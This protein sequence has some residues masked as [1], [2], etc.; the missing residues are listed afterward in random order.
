MGYIKSNG[1]K[2]MEH[3]KKND[4]ST[5]LFCPSTSGNMKINLAIFNISRMGTQKMSEWYMEI[6]QKLVH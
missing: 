1:P 6:I 5:I 4:F 2:L 3:F